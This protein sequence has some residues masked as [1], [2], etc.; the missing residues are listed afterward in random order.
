MGRLVQDKKRLGFTVAP[1]A[2]KAEDECDRWRIGAGGGA[3]GKPDASR[4]SGTSGEKAKAG[5]GLSQRRRRR[6]R[7]A[8]AG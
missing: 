8:E 5:S 3:S 6:A 4:R 7:K 1:W 2:I